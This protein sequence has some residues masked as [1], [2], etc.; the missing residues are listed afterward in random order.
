MKVSRNK[1]QGYLGM[2]ITIT[3]DKFIEIEMKEQI[4]EAIEAFGD[5]ITGTVTSPTARHLFEVN[6]D[7]PLLSTSQADIFHSVTA[8]LLYL[9]KR[10]RPDIETAVAYLTTRVTSP[11]Q[12]DWKKLKNESLFT[13][14]IPSMM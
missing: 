5:E 9:Q 4:C 13:Y 14:R 12:D 2:N 11:N 1:I 6:D 8:K 10:A 3:D 7:N